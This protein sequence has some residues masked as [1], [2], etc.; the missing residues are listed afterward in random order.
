[1]FR[2]SS[3]HISHCYANAWDS[4]ADS[5]RYGSNDAST[6]IDTAADAHISRYA[7]ANSGRANCNA[8]LRS[9]TC[10][11]S[12]EQLR[13]VV[14][15]CVHTAIPARPRLRADPI[16]AVPGNRCRPAWL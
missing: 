4:R 14:P 8:D 5:H 10:G 6:N 12:C 11:S 2:D 15:R 1:M 3:A 7:C 9:R 13:P 16:Q